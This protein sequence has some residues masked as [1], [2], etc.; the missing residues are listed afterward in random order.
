MHKLCLALRPEYKLGEKIASGGTSTVWTVYDANNSLKIMR[1][2]K[3][4]EQEVEF[5]QSHNN[6]VNMQNKF[7]SVGV[8]PNLFDSWICRLNGT[9]NAVTIMEDSG[10]PLYS[11]NDLNKDNLTRVLDVVTDM[12]N[13]I[14]KH[15]WYHG[16]IHQS[17]V[18]LKQVDRLGGGFYINL[19][20]GLY[21]VYL[22]DTDLSGE[23]WFAHY[24]LIEDDM[25][26][27]EMRLELLDF[28]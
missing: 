12:V 1:L 27:T 6:S 11:F 23:L 5:L 13:F 7:S 26:L 14:H 9:V 3:F 8:S 19:P 24:N 10:Q 4:D 2:K 18:T 28:E 15:G 22:I 16:D 25:K 17:N 20:N 21:R